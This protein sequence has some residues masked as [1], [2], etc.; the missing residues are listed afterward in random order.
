[1]HM[2][3]PP[4][5]DIQFTCEECGKTF[6]P[7]PDTMLEIR[8]GGECPCCTGETTEEEAE[9]LLADGDA[10]TTEQL[11]AM[12]EYELAEL[13]LTPEDREK[14]L[15]GEEISAGAVCICRECQE[16]ISH[17]QDDAP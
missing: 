8:L 9:Q 2:S 15:A 5:D 6:E 11:E 7:D 3:P 10:I 16:K 13:G 17:E 4:E 12:S 14:L 1:M